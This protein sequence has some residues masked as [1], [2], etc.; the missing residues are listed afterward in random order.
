MKRR[1]EKIGKKFVVVQVKGEKEKEGLPLIWKNMFIYNALPYEKKQEI[2]KFCIKLF[3]I[4]S[5]EARQEIEPIKI[6]G[7]FVES[8]NFEGIKHL[9]FN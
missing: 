4:L 6:L 5:L 8:I 7:L 2:N 1:I 9:K 3:N